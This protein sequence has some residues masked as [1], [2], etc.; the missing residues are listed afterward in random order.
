[1]KIIDIGICVNNVDPK[2]IGRI[3]Y[4]PYGMFVSEI[5]NGAKYTEWDELD[6]FVALPFLPLHINIIPQIQQ[7]VKIIQYD[8]NKELQ[9]VEYVSGPYTSPHD[10]QNQTFATQ[11]KDTT[12]GGV[13]VKGIKNVRNPDGSYNNTSRG[14][15][16]ADK[17]TGFR[18]NYGSD[19]IFTE[20]GVQLRGGMLLSKKSKN[21]KD[22][23]D[24]PQLSKKMGRFA[25]KKFPTTFVSYT[26]T[27]ETSQTASG[28]LKYL[29]EYEIDNLSAPTELRLYVY[30]I[31]DPFGS[32]QFNTNI[33]GD[34]TL[35][36]YTSSAAQ[37]HLI[38]ND[39][40]STVVSYTK[41]LDGTIASACSEIRDILYQI[42]NQNLT[43]LDYTYPIEDIYPFYFRPTPNFK[44]LKGT[45]ET[46]TANK[47]TFINK[48]QL[49]N[50]TNGTGLIFSR[51]SANPPVTINKQEKIKSKEVKGSGEQ[52]FSF[53][54]S[55]RIYFAST[56]P[57]IGVNV[58]SIDF[59]DLD[60]YELTQDDYI[61]TI[62][63]NTYSTVRGENLYNFLVA[64]KNVIDRHIHNINE[65]PVKTGES[66]FQELNKLMD[67]L[68]DDLL[69][70]SIRIN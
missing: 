68:K 1:M 15:F 44:L 48:V 54:S 17:D 18:G 28:R 51:Q 14:A 47:E 39:D 32:S 66:G 34:N 8:T 58:K 22:L 26:E 7:S 62:E 65:P 40:V 59:N 31:I 56:S 3:R 19:I 21:K 11:H 29:I 50:K 37:V 5:E 41:S 69:N 27:T 52:S 16:I 35:V 49:R 30:K 38:N 55:D 9:N 42:D 23:L 45:T 24:Y 64:L 6:P 33:F 13:I 61:S 60:E 70:N 43:I 20:N 36:N 25:L 53:L 10:S 46:E 67:T 57:N 2:G 63:P 4:R 12:Y